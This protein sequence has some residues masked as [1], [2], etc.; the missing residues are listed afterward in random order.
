MDDL[1]HLSSYLN[2]YPDGIS[3]MN[4]F[5]QSVNETVMVTPKSATNAFI[6][7]YLS[8]DLKPE[9]SELVLNDLLNTS[10][11]MKKYSQLPENI[12]LVNKYADYYDFNSEFFHDCG[13]MYIGESRILY[14]IMTENLNQ[15][16]APEIIGNIINKI[17]NYVEPKE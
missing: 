6:S 1:Q 5:S 14:C 16:Q 10:L 3:F 12:T 4:Y 15:N 7:L 17:Y 13:I 9:N 8:T 2:Y 11:N